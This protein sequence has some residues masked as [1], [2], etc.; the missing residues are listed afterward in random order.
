MFVQA[1]CMYGQV[2]P[3][4]THTAKSTVMYEGMGALAGPHT[5]AY[6]TRKGLPCWH[7]GVDSCAVSVGLTT[8]VWSP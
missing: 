4:Q 2:T 7:L 6:G 1:A 5:H 8:G 3:V